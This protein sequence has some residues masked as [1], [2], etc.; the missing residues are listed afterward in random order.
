M[1]LL[2]LRRRDNTKAKDILIEKRW[3]G[4]R[5]F[6]AEKYMVI[7]DNGKIVQAKISSLELPPHVDPVIIT[8]TEAPKPAEEPTPANEDV[9]ADDVSADTVVM[10][11][12]EVEDLTW[13]ELK[14]FAAGHGIN[15]KKKK[16]ADLMEELES[17]G[18]ISDEE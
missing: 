10:T 15:T 4:G 7:G 5:Q 18:A 3:W 9:P 14:Q 16:R 17:V 1:A 11:L 8:E 2:R 13:Q 12:E 6:N